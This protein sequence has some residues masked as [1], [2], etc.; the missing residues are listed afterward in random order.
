M[1]VP[2]KGLG[3]VGFIG[4][5]EGYAL[6]P[7][8][9]TELTNMRMYAGW[10]E[11]FL[12]HARVFDQ[13][14][15][16]PLW[17][18]PYATTAKK[19]L[20]H[21]GKNAV[22][23]DD[24]AL[25]TDITGAAPTGGLS[26]RWSGGSFNSVLVLN[27]GVDQPMFWGGDVAQNLATLTN[28]SANDRA[29][30]VRFM[31]YFIVALNIT[32]LGVNYPYR[33]KWSGVAAPGTL[34]VWTPATANKA[35]FQDRIGVGA[36]V[37]ALPLGESLVLYFEGSMTVMSFIDGQDVMGFKDLPD[38][39]GML[40]PGCGVVIPKIGHVVLTKGDV[41]VHA[42]NGAE[43]ILED[44]AKQWLQDNID[45][46]YY[47]VSFV[48]ANHARSEVWICF[49]QTGQQFCTLALVWNWRSGALSKRTIPA[50]T[51]GCTGFINYASNTWDSATGI[52]DAQTETWDE[53]TDLFATDT[54]R[55]FM[56]SIDGRIYAMDS[57]ET[58]AGT[59]FTGTA[60]RTGLNEIP[61]AA[62]LKDRV[63]LVSRLWISIDA[64]AGTQLTVQVGGSDDPNTAPTYSAAFTYTVG[65]DRWVD[66]F[67]SGVFLAWKISGTAHFRVQSVDFEVTDGGQF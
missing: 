9:W 19:Y 21:A 7:N 57:G 8:A 11:R 20:V 40:A 37:D 3:E 62:A 15:V 5:Q 49:P 35:G 63:K 65:T 23:V 64:A 55:L 17:I 6:V 46:N 16:M 32:T 50:C 52:W 27:N 1:R 4:D 22:F 41:I 51:Y 12:G 2:I 33:V 56:S 66:T 43:S 47:P 10:A 31:G 60:E 59:A 29:K 54:T 44:K 26:D 48:V 53:E 30:I 45:S 42:G 24:G 28:W 25:R 38:P 39:Y 36:F 58:F 13:C 18:A 61:G 34:P 14:D 67:A